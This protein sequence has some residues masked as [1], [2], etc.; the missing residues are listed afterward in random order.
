VAGT[1]KILKRCRA[2]AAKGAWKTL[3]AASKRAAAEAQIADDTDMIGIYL[4][5]VYTSINL[6]YCLTTPWSLK[7]A[8]C[9]L[10]SCHHDMSQIGLIHARSDACCQH[11][12]CFDCLLVNLKAL[13]MTSILVYERDILVHM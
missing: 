2:E 1:E 13:N 5:V 4:P 6:R 12:D 7:V 9:V 3:R 11:Q 8:S 10:M